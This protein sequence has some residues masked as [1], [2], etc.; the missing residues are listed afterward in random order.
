M[1]PGGARGRPARD[2]SSPSSVHTNIVPQLDDFNQSKEHGLWGEL[3][4]AIYEDVDVE[5]LR[6]SVFGGPIFKDTDFAYRGVLVPRCAPISQSPH[7]RRLQEVRE[8]RQEHQLLGPSV[9]R[10]I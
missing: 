8:G 7:D 6:I 9:G 1:L 4:N 3:E 5:R 10:P 2:A